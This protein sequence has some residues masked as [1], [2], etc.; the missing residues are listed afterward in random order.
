MVGNVE[1]TVLSEIEPPL[2]SKWTEATPAGLWA[3]ASTH[4]SLDTV[5]PL[6]G[7]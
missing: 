5:E 2:T 4:V 6:D 7:R 3:E 1:A